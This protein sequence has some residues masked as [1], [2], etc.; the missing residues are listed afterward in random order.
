MSGNSPPGRDMSDRFD[1]H[2]AAV[3]VAGG[4]WTP[5]AATRAPTSPPSAT[6]CGGHSSSVSTVGYDD[7]HPV[8]LTGRFVA[9][10]L[11]IGGIALTGVV[12][13]TVASWL[14]DRVRNIERE[15]SADVAALRSEVA[16]LRSKISLLRG[17]LP[18][19]ADATAR[20]TP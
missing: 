17:A 7:F 8:T 15:G 14:I 2:P 11:M 10:G 18:T 16:E 19:C 20:N 4:A 1:C 3:R 9:V 5:S 6:H 13:A 12:T